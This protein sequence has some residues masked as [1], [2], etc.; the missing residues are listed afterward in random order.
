MQQV[1]GDSSPCR[2]VVYDWFKRFT[3]G[4]RLEDDPRE[5]RPS[6]SKTQENVQLLINLLEQ[7]RLKTVDKV[8][9]DL[10]ISQGTPFAILTENLVLSKLSGRWVPEALREDQLN[11]RADL[12]LSILNKIDPN[13]GDFFER[14]VTE[15]ET[16]IE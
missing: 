10:G 6:S 16:R 1:Y 15:D 7:D 12:S 5:G 11:R 14:C 4:R 8:A 2:E 9:N 3:E 13:E